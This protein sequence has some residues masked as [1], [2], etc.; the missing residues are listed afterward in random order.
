MRILRL[1]S[2]GTDVM[3]IQGLLAR[4]GYKP[5]PI[6]GI[7]GEQTRQA[8]IDFQRN[9]G[10]TP[11]GVIG[12]A[13]YRILNPLLLGYDT[14][15]V[16]PGDT[17]WRIAQKYYTTVSRIMTA[18]PGIDPY[19]LRIGQRLT[20]PFGIDVV[21]TNIAY[22]YEVLERDIAGLKARYPFIETGSAGQSVLG[23]NLYYLK[24]GNGPNKV[25]YNGG[26]HS[27]EWL[28]VPVLMKWIENFSS[29]YAVSRNIR[30]YDVR[31]IWDQSTIYIIPMV[32][33]DGIDIVLNGPQ[34][35]N[36]YYNQLLEWND[37]G[38]PFSQ[39]WN[40]NTRGVD[41]NHNYD[42]LWYE[43]QQLAEEL[44]YGQP[45]PTRYPGPSPESEPETQ[46]I[47]KFIREH[48]FRL[49]IAY[50]SQ[51]QVI[52]WNFQNLAPPV[53]RT[54]GEMFSNVSGYALDETTGTA[55]Y[56]GM[57]DWFIQEYRRPGY[58]IETGLGVNP[59]PISQIPQIYD[60]NEELLLLAAVV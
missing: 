34:P 31:S 19:R 17:L 20:V 49:I 37:T 3:E 16:Q 13:T 1:G 33:P 6:D 40:A 55:A 53:A 60:E 45:G 14:Y 39:V 36:P 26:I 25:F 58:T 22:N 47:V 29:A 50:H 41:L 23:R 28:P 35:D 11:D 56:S 4:I 42:A 21:D 8:V 10:L 7:F 24:L 52:Y 5:G 15:V 27:L 38:R 32:N 51:G 44:G 46:A 2:R 59:L 18:N 30:G 48:D 57:K 43:Y 9:N 54:I 12:P